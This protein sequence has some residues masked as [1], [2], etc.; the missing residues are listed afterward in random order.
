MVDVLAILI[1]VGCIF[2]FLVLLFWYGL[3]G[4]PNRDPA[5]GTNRPYPDGL[6]PTGPG[7]DVP[8]YLPN[9][10]VSEAESFRRNADRR[11]TRL[12]RQPRVTARSWMDEPGAMEAAGLVDAPGPSPKPVVPEESP[13]RHRRKKHR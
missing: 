2:A 11:L 6:G 3:R 13:R 4:E 5:I 7:A 10:T 8:P 9:F 1:F 12:F